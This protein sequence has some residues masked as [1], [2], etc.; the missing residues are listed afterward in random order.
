VEAE[1]RRQKGFSCAFRD[2][3]FASVS[4]TVEGEVSRCAAIELA[5][6]ATKSGALERGKAREARA[7]ISHVKSQLFMHKMQLFLRETAD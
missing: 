2:D 1:K 3:L 5:A 6:F 4:P 7:W